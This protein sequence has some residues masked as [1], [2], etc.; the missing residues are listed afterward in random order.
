MGL[1]TRVTDTS[2]WRGWRRIQGTPLGTCRAQCSGG[3]HSQNHFHA[4][5]VIH[6]HWAGVIPRALD[7]ARGIAALGGSHLSGCSA[8]SLLAEKL[9]PSC[10]WGWSALTFMQSSWQRVQG[11][12]QSPAPPGSGAG[13][14]GRARGCP[15]WSSLRL[16]GCA[17][18]LG[19]APRAGAPIACPKSTTHQ[20][21]QGSAHINEAT[22]M[23]S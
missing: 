23:R 21:H 3:M 14:W 7:A 22:I 5:S 11:C 20:P 6:V 15:P 18:D 19:S 2:A 12:P 4:R 17:S 1:A 16:P 9:Y 8:P 13:R 10:R